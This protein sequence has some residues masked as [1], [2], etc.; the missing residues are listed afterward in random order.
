MARLPEVTDGT[1]DAQVLKSDI[2]VLVD[3]W[4]EWCGPCKMVTRFLEEIAQEHKGELGVVGLDVDSNTQ[5]AFSYGV[6]SIPT[7]LLFMNGQE[8]ERLVGAVPKD[9]LLSQILPH[10]E[11]D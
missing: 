4:A 2:P 8:V 6:Q 9:K 5:T 1:F 11:A 7:L 10:F 3:F